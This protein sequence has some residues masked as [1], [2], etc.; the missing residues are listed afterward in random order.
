[1]AQHNQQLL[2]S[3]STPAT[4]CSTPVSK[5][6]TNY[7]LLNHINNRNGAHSA[8]DSVNH[9][10]EYSTNNGSTSSLPFVFQQQRYANGSVTPSEATS[11]AM[12]PSISSVATS[13]T[14]ASEVS[15]YYYYLCTPLQCLI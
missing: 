3:K 14:S 13:I 1:M 5:S 9:S 10:L 11:S 8:S 4:T 15:F 6:S 2:S 12:S 7:R